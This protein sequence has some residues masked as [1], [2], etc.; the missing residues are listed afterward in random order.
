ME[1]FLKKVTKIL[2][3][4]FPLPAVIDLDDDDGII[5]AVISK[6]FRGMDAVDRVKIIWDILDKSLTPTERRRVVTIVPVAPEE[7]IAH[8]A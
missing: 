8:L 6:R 1:S 7:E 2:R 5:G 3:D 4:S